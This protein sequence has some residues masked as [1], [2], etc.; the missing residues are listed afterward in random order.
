MIGLGVLEIKM[1]SGEEEKVKESCR[2]SMG[3]GK[4]KKNGAS[5]GGASIWKEET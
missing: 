5:G 3:L 1:R 4:Q 2:E